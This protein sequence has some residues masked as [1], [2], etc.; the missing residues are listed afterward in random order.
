[1]TYTRDLADHVAQLRYDALPPSVVAAAKRVTLDL[2]GVVFPATNY[3][4][5]QVMNDYV[6]GLGGAPQAT[7][8]GTEIRTSTPDAALANGTMAADMEQDDVHPEAGT[9][10]SSVYVPALLA[11]GERNDVPGSEWIAGLVAAYDLGSRLSIA[12]DHARQ[13]SRGFHPTAITGTFGAAAGAARLL[14][15]GGDE[16]NGALGLAGCQAAG[17]MTWEMEQEHFTKSFQSG[18]PARNA[19]VAAELAA[20]GYVGARDTLDGHYNAFDAFSTHRDFPRLVEGLGERYEIEHTGYK[21]YSCCRNIHATLDVVLELAAEHGFAGADVEHITVWLPETLAPIVDGNTLTTHNL[22]F[23]VA[24]A[25]TD[26]EVTRAQTTA[27]RRADPE[28]NALAARITLHGDAGLETVFPEHWPA[29]VH[30]TLRDGRRFEVDRD[31]PRGNA[32]RPVTDGDIEAKFM[33]MATQV[34]PAERAGAIVHCVERL[35]SLASIRELTDLLG[36]DGSGTGVQA[37]AGMT[38]SVR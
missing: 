36:V 28:L 8:I 20:R 18:V 10:P 2:I 13:Y 21:F 7:V 34:I 32:A 25:L 17:L 19:V 29:R 24:A 38:A 16:V 6:R 37:P 23:I 4:P 11:V 33:Q 14:G 22:Q 31:D 9:H 3:G 12:M 5:G 1:M 30:V 27:A 15:L 35:E 26:G